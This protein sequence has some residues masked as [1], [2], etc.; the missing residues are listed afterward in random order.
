MKIK[1]CVCSGAFARVFRFRVSIQN[2]DPPVWRRIEVPGCYTFWDLHCAITDAFG[3]LDY[4][5]H[6]FE[7]RD[8]KTGEGAHIGIP[9]EE[10]DA[11]LGIVMLP[12][13]RQ[14]VTRFFKPN[15]PD[16]MYFYDFGDNWHHPVT[17][18][19]IV[20]RDKNVEYPRC[21]AGENACPPEDCG[22][23]WGFERFKQAIRF[24]NAKNHDEML[25]WVGGWFDPLWLDLNLIRFGDPKVREEICYLGAR[26]PKSLRKV[27]YHR[28]PHP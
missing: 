13:Y 11:M 14:R 22:G 8:P 2:T 12:D 27:Q 18:E 28:M 3:W 16:A 1:S 5:L 21:V 26:V 15:N 9:S 23:P 17:L 19:A 24:Q 7:M 4:H 25:A 6:R 10:D 20:P